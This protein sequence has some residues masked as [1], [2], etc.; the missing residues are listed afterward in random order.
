MKD[1]LQEYLDAVRGRPFE[2]GEHDCALFAAKAV[3]AMH[4][5]GFEAVVRRYGC[6]TAL[7]YRHLQRN[8]G[9][10]LGDLTTTELGPSK[11]QAVRGDVALLKSGG[12]ESLGIAVPPLVL[13][14]GRDGIMPMAMAHAVKF[15]GAK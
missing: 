1:A 11:A 7:D 8:A 3:D 14:A 12:R 4:G 2:W 9:V 10:T 6:R 15:W 13:V 5:T